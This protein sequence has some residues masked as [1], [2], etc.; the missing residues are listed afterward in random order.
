MERAKSVVSVA[1]LHKLA[2]DFDGLGRLFRSK[3]TGQFV[4]FEPYTLGEKL[5]KGLAEVCREL[6]KTDRSRK[7]DREIT[8][9]L[10]ILR[11][12]VRKA[13]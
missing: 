9:K 6:G 3:R 12:L 7:Q 10:R 5:S 8:R 13:T 4:V 1:E 2:I 11:D